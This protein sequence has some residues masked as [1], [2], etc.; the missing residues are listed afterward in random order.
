MP[1]R[2]AF[3]SMPQSLYVDKDPTS[4]VIQQNLVRPTIAPILAGVFLSIKGTSVT[5]FQV[6]PDIAVK[7]RRIKR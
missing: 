2:G 5:V 6:G 4:T 3:V 1:R 7:T